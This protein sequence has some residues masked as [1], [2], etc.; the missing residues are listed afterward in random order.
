LIEEEAGFL[1]KDATVLANMDTMN[2][3]SGLPCSHSPSNC[4]LENEKYP[5]FLETLGNWLL[6]NGSL[7]ECHS[8]L[9]EGRL[10]GNR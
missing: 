7:V 1:R 10:I 8:C 3:P 2:L 9:P 5:N 6:W 4:A